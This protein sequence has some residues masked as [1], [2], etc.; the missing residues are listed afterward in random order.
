MNRFVN[1]GTTTALATILT[2]GGAFADISG[3]Q[4]WNDYK[5]YMDGFGHSITSTETVTGDD[6]TI[7]DLI[8]TVPLPED[9]GTVTM[10]YGEMSFITNSDGTASVS[11]PDNM[12]FDIALRP[13]NDKAV[14]VK[15]NYKHD[16]LSMIASGS[17]GDTT[18]TFNAASLGMELVELV[19]DGEKVDI[20]AADMT[21]TNISGKA[22]MKTGNLRS[23]T[24]TGKIESLTY[25]VAFKDPKGTG[26][27]NLKGGLDNLAFDADMAM[28][29]VADATDM[30]AMMAA[31]FAVNANFS[32][33]G[34][35]TEIDFDDKGNAMKALSTTTSGN[36]GIDMDQTRLQYGGTSNGAAFNMTNSDLPFPISLE[37]AEAAFNLM[38]PIAISDE[39][40]DFAFMVK[41][42]DIA[43][44]DMLW[45]MIDASAQLP[46]DPATILL[47]LSGKAKVFLNMVSPNKADAM[48]METPG[49]LNA[50][51]L[52]SLIVSAAGAA[53][54]GNGAFT[55]DNTDLTTFDG[56]PAPTGTVDLKLEGG[57]GL[58]DKLVAMGL[59]PE[60][61]AM[62]A[63]M[64]VGM[65]SVP[66]GDDV[67][68]SKI[69]VTAD[70]GISANGM[71]IK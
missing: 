38:M 64:M 70:G 41:F 4:L 71:R 59:L 45:D 67:L 24:E 18:Y 28:P 50:L 19:I 15:L 40:Q 44:P 65:F 10:T 37:M 5:T 66:S 17:V 34:S 68:T 54:T 36:L 49:E 23:M 20:G 9:G 1:L 7:T 63:R 6:I 55:F 43:V 13:T 26:H 22:A 27:F 25:N 31:G 8:I 29:L 46:R 51:T 16:D 30:A 12:P 21:M 52:N 61:Q 42:G 60:D 32:H 35:T 53:L 57:N 47:D 2:T 39:E 56:M 14:D 48:A 58:L 11:I 62:G 69:E 33:Q 3:T